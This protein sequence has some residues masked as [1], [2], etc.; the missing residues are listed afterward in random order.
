MLLFYCRVLNFA[1]IIFVMRVF[2]LV[3]FFKSRKFCPAKRSNHKTKADDINLLISWANTC[4]NREEKRRSLWK[5]NHE[6]EK[7]FRSRRCGINRCFRLNSLIHS[8]LAFFRVSPLLFFNS[9]FI[10][11]NDVLNKA[12]KCTF[13]ST[14]NRLLFYILRNGFKL[15]FQL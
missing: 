6:N 3:I 5:S 15:D 11:G 9:L 8:L 10:V 12:M 4:E 14:I 2:N 13:V 1:S 7:A